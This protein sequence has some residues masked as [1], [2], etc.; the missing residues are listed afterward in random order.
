MSLFELRAA[1]QAGALTKQRYIDQMHQRHARL[2]EYADFLEGTDIERIEILD[3]RVILT[4][5]ATGIRIVCDRRDLRIAPLEVLNFGD[6]EKADA[7]MMFRLLEDNL[8]ILDIGA[9]I[10]WYSLRFAKAFPNAKIFS[11]EPIPATFGYLQRN[12][13]LNPACRVHPFNFGFSDRAGELPF[14]FHPEGSGSASAADLL[15]T[16]RAERIT[17]HLRTLD[18]WVA[19]T[20]TRIDFIKCDVEGAE[21]LV[22]TGGTEALQRFKPM[23]FAEMLRKWTAKFNYHPNRIIDLM[24]N[25]GY[26]CFVN[27]EDRLVEFPT[28]ADNTVETNFF[29]LHPLAHAAKI[30]GLTKSRKA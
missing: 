8:T 6:Y 18:D 24:S 21:L 14:Y 29:F 25:L 1:Y 28:M 9:N 22:L 3:G 7:D 12:I 17:C 23:V 30:D 15:G 13:A 20:G 11:F 19:E 26:R 5:R 16:G 10:G 27:R 4:S 2:F